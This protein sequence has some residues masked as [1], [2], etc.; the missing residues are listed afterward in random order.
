MIIVLVKSV[1]QKYLVLRCL[2][3]RTSLTPNL[4]VGIMGDTEDYPMVLDET[5]SGV[6]I[7][8]FILPIS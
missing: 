1:F 2:Y 4:C 7:I 8:L 3:V 5:L 6:P